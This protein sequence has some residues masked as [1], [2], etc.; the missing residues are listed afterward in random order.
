MTPA[1]ALL[2]D[3]RSRGIELEADAAVRIRWRPAFMV[4]APEAEAI[5][6]ERPALARLLALPD[7]LPRC[8]LCLW[9]LDSSG[10]CAK[11]FDRRCIDCEKMT[12]SYFVLTCVECGHAIGEGGLGGR[13]H[14]S[15]T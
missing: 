14:R 7:T 4:T 8:P 13:G 2:A 3:L 1:E 6:A 10:R 11:C 15:H 5:R 12:G 9:T